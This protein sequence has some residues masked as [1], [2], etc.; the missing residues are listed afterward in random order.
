MFDQGELTARAVKADGCLEQERPH[1]KFSSSFN[2]W[3]TSARTPGSLPP[4]V[5]HTLPIECNEHRY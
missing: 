2:E 3:A 1:I 5:G 4:K